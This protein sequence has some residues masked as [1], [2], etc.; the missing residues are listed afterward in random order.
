MGSSLGLT[1]EVRVAHTCQQG[2]CLQGSK[3]E[4]GSRWVPGHQHQGHHFPQ[5]GENCIG[6]KERTKS[7]K[8]SVHIQG[9][10]DQSHFSLAVPQHSHREAEGSGHP[11]L[12][13]AR[14]V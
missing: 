7:R 9:A 13:T 2:F 10:K 3:Q 1:S 5:F 12:L 14:D 4:G 6:M 8:V 11:A